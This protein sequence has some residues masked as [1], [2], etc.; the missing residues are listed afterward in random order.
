LTGVNFSLHVFLYA[1]L[2]INGWVSSTQLRKHPRSIWDGS[3]SDSILEFWNGRTDANRIVPDGCKKILVS[4]KDLFNDMF[5]RNR[6]EK[7]YCILWILEQICSD[8]CVGFCKDESHHVS[9]VDR[10]FIGFV[11]LMNRDLV[12][13]RDLR[14]QLFKDRIDI[15]RRKIGI[16]DPSFHCSHCSVPRLQLVLYTAIFSPI[17]HKVGEAN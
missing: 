11:K 3:R 10:Q 7:N 15:F 5:D 16:F 1:G 13:C 9:H 6:V 12:S 4:H 17:K 2:K 8:A 14:H